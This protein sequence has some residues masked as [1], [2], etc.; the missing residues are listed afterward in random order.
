MRRRRTI[1]LVIVLALLLA[2]WFVTNWI[3]KVEEVR[4]LVTSEGRPLAGAIVRVKATDFETRT[5]SNGEYVLKGFRARF[6]VP[7][8]TWVDGYY[9]AG[10][11]ASPWNRTLEITLQPYWTSD[12]PSYSWVPPVI[13]DRPAFEKVLVGAG[14]PIAARLSFNRLF[15][16]LASR[17]KLGCADCHGT[18]IYQEYASGAHAQGAKNIRFLTTY[19][20][21][22]VNGNKS[23]PTSYAFS[24]DYGSFPLRPDPN[25]PWYGPGFKLDFPDQA[26]NCA[27]CHMPGEAVKAPLSSDIN[28]IPATVVQGV[29]CDFCHK[30]VN[31]RLNPITK[32]PYENMPGVLSMELRRPK[33][34]PQMFF[35]PFDDVDVGPDTF[36]PLQND[37]RFCASCHN[38]SFWGTPIYQSYAEWLASPYPQEGK[39]CQTCHMKPDGKTKNF[40]PGRGGLNRDP[41]KIFTHAFPGAANVELLQDTAKLDLSAR[42]QGG[43]VIVE[44]RVTNENGGHDIPTDQPMRNIL[45]LV[46]ATGAD[47]KELEYLG[48]QR[49]PEWGGRGSDPD[50]Y[51][52][53]PGKGYAKVLE[54]LWTK[55]YPTVAYWRQT[56]IR[57]DTRI[58]ALETDKTSYTFRIAEQGPVTVEAR[59]IFR[60]AFKELAKAKGWEL[61][62]IEMEHEV[63][64]VP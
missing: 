1:L 60:R 41:D 54:E 15:L 31:V 18:I 57:E 55:V 20:G 17:L 6:R 43:S 52:G 30:T 26:G 13:E 62:E 63:I 50:D 64:T 53:R 28:K 40:A 11:V 35:G 9:I 44:V 16:P 10:G 33:G 22:D 49:V 19:N 59:L 48:D 38:A 32:L 37:S 36:S 42:R 3:S 12:N 46:S 2:G 27:T 58:P 25:Q 7:V 8:S 4:G 5:D 56:V 21:T 45:L 39:T 29:H 61:G 23:P 51:A 34:E 14:L 47:G 24:Q